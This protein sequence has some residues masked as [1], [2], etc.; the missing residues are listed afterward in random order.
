M[1]KKII[2]FPKQYKTVMALMPAELRSDFKRAMI[3]A[4]IRSEERPV[5]RTKKGVIEDLGV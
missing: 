5:V 4:I 2:K 3:A 1:S